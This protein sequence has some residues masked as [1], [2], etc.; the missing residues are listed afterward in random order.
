MSNESQ[1]NPTRTTFQILLY[2]PLTFTSRR[3][4]CIAVPASIMNFSVAC[5]TQGPFLISNSTRF[6]FVFNLPSPSLFVDR[7]FHWLAGEQII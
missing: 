1:L 6:L 3:A 4:A 2:V 7:I 5:Q